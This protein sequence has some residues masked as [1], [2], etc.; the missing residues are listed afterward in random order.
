MDAKLL[1]KKLQ[2]YYARHS[3]I[4]SVSALSLMLG[5]P[6][7][8]ISEMMGRLAEEGVL[9]APGGFHEPTDR[10]FESWLSPE[11]IPA[12]PPARIAAETLSRDSMN[13]QAYLVPKPSQTIML[14]VRGD[15][16]M[17]AGICDGDIAIV[18]MARQGKAGDIVVAKIDGEF[19][20][21]RLSKKG[22]KFFLKPENR[23]YS[24]LIPV[25]ELEIQGVVTGLVRKYSH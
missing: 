24:D 3:E 18:D 20:L 17:D 14:P 22:G 12:G 10:F 8:R 21:K 19:T 23:S 4:P 9:A 6:E 1:L 13:L 15:S 16:M 5:K 25:Q 7:E 2:D 11:A